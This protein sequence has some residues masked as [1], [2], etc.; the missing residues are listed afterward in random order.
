MAR[1]PVVTEPFIGSEAVTAGTASHNQL[2]RHYRRVFHDVYIC[3]H[4]ELTPAVR[5]KAAWLWSRR[6]GVVAGFSASALHGS[7]WIDMTQAAELIHDN[8]NHPPGLQIRGDRLQSDEVQTV[9]G[10][11]ITVPARTALDLA[12]WYPT[13]TAVP[14]IDALARACELKMS[15][16]DPLMQRYPGRRGIKRA[17]GSVNMVDAGAQSPKESWLRMVLVQAGFP[18]PQTQIPASDEFGDVI[19]YLDM[20]W[21]ELRVAVEYDGEQH[22]TDR[23]QYKWDNRRREMLERLGWIV[24]RVLAGDQPAD[25]VRRVSDALA[26]RRA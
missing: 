23:R 15:D 1:C 7:R 26:R 24:V 11:P 8:R 12:C 9:D 22:R 18:K 20:G 17:R 19:V 14:A 25:I 5:A 13:S 3:R 6:R 4:V 2:R 16:V 21:P 10:V